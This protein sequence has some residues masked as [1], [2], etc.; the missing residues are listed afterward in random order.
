MYAKCFFMEHRQHRHFCF[1]CPT[2]FRSGKLHLYM[3]SFSQTV[4]PILRVQSEIQGPT[5]QQ[6]FMCY[7]LLH[8]FA[9]L[10]ETLNHQTEKQDYIWSLPS[11]FFPKGFY[12]NVYTLSFCVDSASSGLLNRACEICCSQL[13]SFPLCWYTLAP[14]HSSTP[15]TPNLMHHT[16]GLKSRLCHFLAG[17]WACSLTSLNLFPHPQKG[18]GTQRMG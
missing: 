3:S 6:A 1:L 9:I 8:D 4:L 11:D 2:G 10:W 7:S 14:Q 16:I 12:T 13:S 15:L 5:A 18:W 17:S